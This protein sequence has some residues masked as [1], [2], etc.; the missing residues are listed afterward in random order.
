[1]GTVLRTKE[2]KK[3]TDATIASSFLHNNSNA[4]DDRKLYI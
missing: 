1:M 2:Q 3:Q 4:Y